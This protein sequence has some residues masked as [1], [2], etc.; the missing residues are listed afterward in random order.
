MSY[1]T[2]KLSGIIRSRLSFGRV[3]ARG[4]LTTY[5]RVFAVE[6]NKNFISDIRSQSYFT[7]AVNLKTS[8][9]IVKIL[10]KLKSNKISLQFDNFTTIRPQLFKNYKITV[11]DGFMILKSCSQLV[12]RSTEDRIKLVDECWNELLPI[13]ETPTKDYLILLLQAY[14]RAGL[15]SLNDYQLFF[16]KY[17]CPL[18]ADLYAELLY[19]ACQNGDTMETAETLLKDIEHQKIK[20][21]ERIFSALILGYS[22]QGIDAV[23]KVLETMKSKGL[24]P[25][26]DTNTELIKAYILNGNNNRA[27]EILHQSNDYNSDQLFDI[28][29]SA[30]NAS[31]ETIVKEAISL[32][33]ETIQNA[34][35]IAT[36]LQ[37]ICV[38]MVHLNCNRSTTLDPYQLIIQHLPV[39]VFEFENT[40]EYGAFLIKEMIVANEKM[41][42]ILR[43]CDNLIDSQRNL[44]AIHICCVYSLTFNLPSSRDF[45]EALA[46]REQLRPH[47]FWPLFARASNQSDVIDIIKFG[48]KFNVIFDT[49]TLIN[50]V[51]PKANTLINSQKTV[52]ALTDAGVRMLHL[53]TAIITYLLNYNRPKEALDIA[54]L[55]ASPFDPIFIKPALV[56]FVKCRSYKPNAHTISILIKKLQ[57]RCTDKTF[58]LAG[59]IA[60]SICNKQ[61]QRVNFTL[62]NELLT[63]YNRFEVNI[64]WNS[65]NA[66]L[67]ELSKNRNIKEKLGP[68]VQSL[69]NNE[70][71]ADVQTDPKLAAKS[72]S[73]IET[74]QQ[75]LSEFK[76]NDLPVHGTD[77]LWM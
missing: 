19:I 69:I 74:L 53:K 62:T 64:S 12:N 13:L 75:Q 57:N 2:T 15:K 6:S 11:E 37:N 27:I 42:N 14:R 58:D 38:E 51:L 47:Y 63:D 72:V 76:A 44:Y 65:A 61:D 3:I 4:N 77:Y 39:P 40:N 18:D 30:A 5:S 34:K 73:D 56:K 16:E 20:P 26:S 49:N 9:P 32:L 54:S 33:P 43:F 59:Q 70:L 36:N 31:D 50:W 66:I 17:N 45:L 29:R 21:N 22:K 8:T 24:V 60:L 55:S 67:E 25:S 23:E 68:I 46:A 1:V 28:I 48:T 52:K 10:S 7:K 41:S 71:F 35:Q